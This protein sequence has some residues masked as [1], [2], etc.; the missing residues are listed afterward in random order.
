MI[1][2]FFVGV[3]LATA[4]LTALEASSATLRD[5][6]ETYQSSANAKEFANAIA[7]FAGGCAPIDLQRMW[8]YLFREKDKVAGAVSEAS[9]GFMDKVVAAAAAPGADGDSIRAAAEAAWT[10][11]AS[12][13]GALKQCLLF[14]TRVLRLAGDDAVALRKLKTGKLA[15]GGEWQSHLKSREMWDDFTREI[16]EYLLGDGNRSEANVA[17]VVRLQ[18]WQQHIP[19]WLEGGKVYVQ[20]YLLI[21]NCMFPEECDVTLLVK[22]QAS[23]KKD[24][25]AD[26]AQLKIVAGAAE[27]VKALEE[28]VKQLKN[29]VAGTPKSAW[30]SQ[31]QQQQQQWQSQQQQQWQPGYSNAW[32]PTG[33]RVCG[34]CGKTGHI[35]QFCPEK[36]IPQTPVEGAVVPKK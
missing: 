35:A 15:E 19:D 10:S 12:S 24:I 20:K 17:A 2:K 5:I 18:M 33:K 34:K 6:V 13:S 21:H 28:E 23:A 32:V 25:S 9:Q 30:G 26:L 36:E 29:M 11:E 31:G 7:V 22:A 27:R 3:A 1:V 16:Q 4:T 14:G 8:N